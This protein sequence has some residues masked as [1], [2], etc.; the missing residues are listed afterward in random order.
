MIKLIVEDSDIPDWVSIM[1]PLVCALLCVI[2]G[3]L[4]VVGGYEWREA[5]R[6]S[7]AAINAFNTH[8]DTFVATRATFANETFIVNTTVLRPRVQTVNLGFLYIEYDTMQFVAKFA[9]LTMHDTTGPIPLMNVTVWSANHARWLNGSAPALTANKYVLT[10]LCLVDDAVRITCPNQ[11]VPV[12]WSS[13]GAVV[14]SPNVLVMSPLDPE[15]FLNGELETWSNSG[16]AVVCIA[17]LL[18]IIAIILMAFSF[19]KSVTP[20]RIWIL[21]D[22]VVLCH[23]LCLTGFLILDHWSWQQSFEVP[24][25]M[26][27]LM[28]VRIG[29]EAQFVIVELLT[30]ATI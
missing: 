24:G 6:S 22:V 5:S 30:H 23:C 18:L 12:D 15:L 26:G 8:V 16:L 27:L 3:A 28:V 9:S 14:I 19:N 11:Y 25:L 10:T 1:S 21:G 17:S 20:K 13:G 7:I 4:F 29:E 2:S